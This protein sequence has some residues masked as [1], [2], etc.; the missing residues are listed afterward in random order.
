MMGF[1]PNL[2]PP[3]KPLDRPSLSDW[4]EAYDNGGHIPNAPAFVERWPVDAAAF[5]DG[6]GAR[7]RLDLPYRGGLNDSARE[8]LDLFLPEGEPKGLAVFIHGG[9]WLRFGR[10]SWSHLAAGAV[11]RGWAVA[12]PSYSLAPRARISSI[13]SQIARA[14]EEAAHLVPGPIALAGH[15]AGGHL[16]TRMACANSPLGPEAASRLVR[17]VSISGLHDL[18]PL[19]FTAM[20]ADL[21]LDVAEAAAESA[22]LHNPA[23]GTRLAAWVGADERPEF[24]R[25]SLLI[26][27]MWGG[28]ADTRLVVEPGRHHFD[29]IAPLSDP[30]SPLTETLTDW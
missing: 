23:P 7:A 5:R 2:P 15:S 3:E 21:N 18:R 24:V 11:A 1:R 8:R 12:L 22:A 27:V 19:R 6:M 29:V 14:V 9:Y 4:T 10:E 30:E 20:N 28:L 17:T 26:A 13:T 25:Q 16:A